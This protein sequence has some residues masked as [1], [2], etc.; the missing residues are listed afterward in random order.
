M[1]ALTGASR[2][3]KGTRSPEYPH[4]CDSDSVPARID[5]D[6]FYTP[7]RVFVRVWRR[8]RY[9]PESIQRT[10]IRMIRGIFCNEDGNRLNLNWNE[11]SLNCDNWNW[12]DNRNPNIAVFA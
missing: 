11:D 1:F 2:Q 9:S 8:M 4:P 5:V 3:Y 7:C 10:V 6:D 12:D